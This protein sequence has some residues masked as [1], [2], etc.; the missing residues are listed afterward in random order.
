MKRISHASEPIVVVPIIVE[1]VQVQLAITR[2]LVQIG[3]M[4]ITIELADGNVQN[5]AHATTLRMLSGLYR[6]RHHNAIIFAPSILVFSKC[7]H[8]PFYPKP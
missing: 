4:T 3:H 2:V 7:L 5:I 8:T 6:I 1:V